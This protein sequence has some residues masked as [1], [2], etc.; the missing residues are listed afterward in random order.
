[1]LFT[2]DRLEVVRVSTCFRGA[3]H[4]VEEIGKHKHDA[5]IHSVRNG[6]PFRLKGDKINISVCIRHE[7][8]IEKNHH[9]QLGC[10]SHCNLEKIFC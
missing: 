3:G 2:V 1:M 9:V 5:V 8:S 7:R 6:N 10:L 4:L